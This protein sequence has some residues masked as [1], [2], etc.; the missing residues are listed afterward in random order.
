[1]N[2]LLQ[3]PGDS[4][5][6]KFQREVVFKAMHRFAAELRKHDIDTK[7]SNQITERGSL[8][9]EV[10]HGD[11]IDFAYEVRMRSHPMPDESLA[12]KAIGELNQEELFYRA[13]VHL[14]EGGQDYDIMGWSEEQVVVDMLNQYENHLHFLHTVR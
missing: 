4:A 6:Q 2:N 14:V 7:I 3:Y 12:R 5:V 11:E 9:L 8:R 13:E 10:S 1:M